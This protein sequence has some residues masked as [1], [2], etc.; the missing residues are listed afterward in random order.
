MSVNL[1]LV[2]VHA[3]LFLLVIV[4]FLS[5]E[6]RLL[7]KTMMKIMSHQNNT[8]SSQ[9]IALRNTSS[10]YGESDALTVT[11]DSLPSLS[12]PFTDR[13]GCDHLSIVCISA[14]D[15]QTGPCPARVCWVCV[16]EERLR[17]F[18]MYSSV[19]LCF[20]NEHSCTLPEL[21]LFI[22]FAFIMCCYE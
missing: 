22:F 15:V 11:L 4:S 12:S 10:E 9:V 8:D 5:G 16:S 19:S 13:S 17:F 6:K 21:I 2:L 14:P 20:L 7:I 3:Y 18:W 1:V